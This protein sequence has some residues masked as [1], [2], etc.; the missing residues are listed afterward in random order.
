MGW[1]V[2]VVLAVLQL[3]GPALMSDPLLDVSQLQDGQEKPHGES[4]HGKTEDL[5][6][7]TL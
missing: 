7:Q 4:P 5:S 6:S 2:A 3:C 1:C